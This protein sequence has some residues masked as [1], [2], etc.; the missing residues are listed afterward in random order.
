M[1]ILT[2]IKDAQIVNKTLFL[3][4]L[5][6][7]FW[8]RLAF[9]VVDWVKKTHPSQCVIIQSTGGLIRSKR[10]RKAVL[11]SLSSW[12]EMSVLSCLWTLELLFLGLWTQRFIAVT[13]WFSAWW[14]RQNS[15][16]SIQESPACRDQTVGLLSLH[17]HGVNS[18]NKFLLTYI[19]YILVVHGVVRVRHDLAS[20]PLLISY[21]FCFFSGES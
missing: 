14:L 1:I 7:C 8:K 17:N 18:Y 6:G 4:V 19:F 11:L 15:V 5:W 12:A 21:W 16:I 9:D 10:W 2:G 20:P 3:G 13:P